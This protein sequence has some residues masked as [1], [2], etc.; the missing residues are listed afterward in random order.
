M[1]AGPFTI[2]IEEEYLLVVP[3][4]G[5]LVARRDPAMMDE[6]R[7]ALGE[8]VSMELLQAQVEVGT[9]ACASIGEARRDLGALRRTVV[10]VAGRHGAA[11]IAASTHPFAEWHEQRIS[12]DD[13]YRSITAEYRALARRQLVCGMH[14]HIGIHDPELRIALMRRALP[15]LPVLLA[16]GTSSP[17]WRGHDTGLKAFRPT[18]FNELPRTGTPEALDDWADWQTLVELLAASGVC[19][20]P[21]K[22]WWDVRPSAKLPTLELRIAEVCTGIEDALT[23][24]AVWQALLRRLAGQRDRDAPWSR[25][26]RTLVEENKWRAQRWGTAAELADYH[27]TR[28]VPFA[29]VVDELVDSLREDAAALGCGPEVERARDIVR[30]GTS[31]D[32]QLAVFHERKAAGAADDEALRAVVAWLVEATAST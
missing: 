1:A 6:L 20:D 11:P 5:A 10:E 19:D 3:A 21:T 16:L 25:F 2:G 15:F 23:I 27:G 13:R 31:A 17:F 7:A 28:L 26:R 30:R 9:A 24:A 29:E 14:V 22:I 32:R 18:I 4:T 12:D 8:R